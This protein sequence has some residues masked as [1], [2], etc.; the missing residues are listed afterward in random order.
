MDFDVGLG[1][2]VTVTH[3]LKVH[4]CRK[5]IFLRSRDPQKSKFSQGSTS[6]SC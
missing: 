1:M 2:C 4:N 5:Y 3:Q 6:R